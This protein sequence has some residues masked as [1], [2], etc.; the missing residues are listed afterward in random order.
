MVNRVWGL[1]FGKLLVPTASNFG[2]SGEPPTYPALLDDLAARFIQNGWSVKWLVREIVLS[3]A[4]R[5]SAAT[6]ARNAERDAANEL[7]S[8]SPC[9]W[10]RPVNPGFTRRRRWC[11]SE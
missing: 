8:R 1:F 3:A 5:Q 10:A 2:H 4:Y 11:H 7:L 6:D 9:T